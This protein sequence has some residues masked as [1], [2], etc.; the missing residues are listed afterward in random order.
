MEE[1]PT[2][3]KNASGKGEGENAVRDDAIRSNGRRCRAQ[4]QR[5]SQPSRWPQREAGRG[6][7]R[8]YAEGCLEN[9]Y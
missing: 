1:K 9:V 2:N 6:Q 5:R 4:P 8:G 3:T 7:G